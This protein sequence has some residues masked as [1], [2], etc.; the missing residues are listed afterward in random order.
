MSNLNDLTVCLSGVELMHQP[1]IQPYFSEIRSLIS[2]PDAIYRE[3]Y[4]PP[5]YRLAEYC[6]RMPYSQNQF[7]EPYGFLERQLKLTIATLKLRRGI[8]LP[9]NEFAETIAEQEPR[10]VYALFIVSLLKNLHQLHHDREVTLHPT[11]GELLGMWS[12]L[13]GSLYKASPHYKM[14]FASDPSTFNTDIVMAAM[15]GHIYPP[16]IVSWLSSN[17]ALFNQWWSAI[18]H[19]AEA[20]NDI[21]K[22]IQLAADKTGI[23]LYGKSEQKPIVDWRQE[24]RKLLSEEANSNPDKMFRTNEGLFVSTDI[25]ENFINITSSIKHAFFFEALEK[26]NWLVLNNGK[27]YHKLSSKRL[28]NSSVMNGLIFN[29][30]MLPENLLTLC[31]DPRFTQ[32]TDL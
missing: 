27:H 15:A 17:Q 10:W 21:D 13:A 24:L 1:K 5:L 28:E 6:Q 23:I 16:S 9:K 12:P 32:H 29:L 7:N 20:Q 8:L 26:D 19:Q 30:D 2:C 22:I 18:L 3:I 4:L 11:N 14:T 25:I 31:I